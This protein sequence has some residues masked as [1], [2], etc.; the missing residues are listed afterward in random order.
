MVNGRDPSA[1]SV[2]FPSS[3]FTVVDHGGSSSATFGVLLGRFP[4]V[5]V[6]RGTSPSPLRPPRRCLRGEGEMVEVE[7]A[8]VAGHC[9][10]QW[11]SR[12]IA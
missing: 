7:V 8:E 6:E 4:S 10:L 12:V 9:H 1:S 11:Q 5:A 3:C 2:A